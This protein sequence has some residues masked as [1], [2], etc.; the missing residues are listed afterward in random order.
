MEEQAV[1]GLHSR[2]SRTSAQSSPTTNNLNSSNGYALA[3]PMGGA[4]TFDYYQLHWF[5][6]VVLTILG[7]AVVMV[8][9]VLSRVRNVIEAWT[10]LINPLLFLFC[11]SIVLTGGFLVLCRFHATVGQKVEKTL[12]IRREKQRELLRILA[13]CWF[14]VI[15]V[16]NILQPWLG[17]SFWL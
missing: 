13:W 7:G 3:G 8:T 2:T 14:G 17:P 5:W 12:K 16:Y 1:G 9:A 10:V 15:M 4:T 11:P 6:I